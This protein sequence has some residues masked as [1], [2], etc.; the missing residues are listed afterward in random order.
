[1]TRE[2][3]IEQI[4]QDVAQNPI[5]VYAKGEKDMA[6]QLDLVMCGDDEVADGGAAMTKPPLQP[7]LVS[8]GKLQ[9]LC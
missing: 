4:K 3:W 1:M 7:L 5:M 9:L 6:A 2:Q 8:G